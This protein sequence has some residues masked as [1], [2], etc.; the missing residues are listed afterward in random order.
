MYDKI[1]W[2]SQII[3]KMDNENNEYNSIEVYTWLIRATKKKSKQQF[4]HTFDLILKLGC[5]SYNV[6][7]MAKFY[8][9][10]GWEKEIW[11]KK[12][13]QNTTISRYKNLNE[14]S[15]VDIKWMKSCHFFVA[16]TLEQ[17]P[18]GSI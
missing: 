18:N 14:K 12:H 2:Q 13:L 9:G 15:M 16:K 10:N 1:E 7:F 11:K 8:P 4:P 17:V 6:Y 5:N 3:H